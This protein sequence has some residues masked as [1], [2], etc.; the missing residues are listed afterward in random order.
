MIIEFWLE[1]DVSMCR[2]DAALH[3]I[4]ADP[5]PDKS[6]L[7]DSSGRSITYLRLSVTDQCQ[8]RCLYCMP[9]EGIKALPRDEYMTADEMERFVQAAAAMGVWRLRL[10]GGEP[11]LRA[12]IVSLVSRF[13]KIPGLRDLALTTNGER[14]PELAKDLK[15]A[16]LQRINISLDSLDPDRF[17]QITLSKSFDKVWDGIH[18]CLDLGLKVKINAVA[19]RG[20]TDEEIDGFARLAYEH[21]LEVR[22]IEFMPL[23]GTGW[24]P[25]LSL[26]IDAVRS[27][28]AHKYRM[29][30]S[31]R[32]SEV[33]ESF[34]L[35]GGKGRVGFIASMTEPFCSTCSRI[36][37]S[38]TGKIQLCLFSP[39][40]FDMLPA[41]RRGADQSDIQNE[42]RRAVTRKPASHPWADGKT[43]ARPERNAMIRTI[44]G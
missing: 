4:T 42:I 12:D 2:M 6:K 5:I 15:L 21:P 20:I 23:C 19:M 18:R 40:T 27:R 14:L 37:I 30:P 28:I 24:K 31:E 16:G 32:G 39:L 38:A 35:F 9:P 34:A 41:L 3:P 11:L 33:A 29:I 10:T 26:P 13:S 44:G 25:E 17:A 22:F 43:E 1:D 36:R 8:F 7:I